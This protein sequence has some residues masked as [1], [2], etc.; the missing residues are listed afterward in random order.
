MFTWRSFI[1]YPTSSQKR[2][3]IWLICWHLHTVFKSTT[4]HID[5]SKCVTFKVVKQ[6]NPIGSIKTFTKH[7]CNIY[8]DER[9]AILKILRDKRITFMKKNR[10]YTGPSGTKIFP[11]SFPKHWWSHITGERVRP[12]NIFSN[13]TVQK[14]QW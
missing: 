13:L 14:R 8:M 4:P 2:T 12:Y 1:R 11:L 6:L 10:I 7:N 5:L 3:N 9:L